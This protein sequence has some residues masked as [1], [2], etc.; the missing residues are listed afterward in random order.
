MQE[1]INLKGGAP[2][3]VNKHRNIMTTAILYYTILYYT[4]LYYTILY[5]TI[6][7][8][9][10]LYYTIQYNT[11][12]YYTILY[13]TILYNTILYYTIQYYTILY[14]TQTVH[15]IHAI[16][17]I[18]ASNLLRANACIIIACC[19]SHLSTGLFNTFFDGY[20]Y[21]FY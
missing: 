19:L 12:L 10:I 11:I 4:I 3:H 20:R 5:Y 6:L 8:Y 14:Y 7:Y 13:Y 21:S 1:Q 18:E 2:T 17:S 9:T 15:P 16:C